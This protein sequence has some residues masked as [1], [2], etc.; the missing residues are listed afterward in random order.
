MKPLRV[1]IAG[2][3]TG[4]HI[5]PA[6]AIGHALK[7]MNAANELLFVGAKGKMEMS[8]VP[9]E[10]FNIVGL[11]IAGFNRSNILKNI[12]LPYK[13]LKSYFAARKILSE[14]KPDVVVGVGGYASFPMLNAAQ[15][16]GIPTLVQEQNSY[17]GKSNKLL[18]KKA[19]AICVAYENMDRFFPEE[20][21]ITTGNPVRKSISESVINEEQGK[22]WLGLDKTKTTIL[23]IGGS[24]GARSINEAIDMHLETILGWNVQLLWQTG[25]PYYQQAAARAEKFTGQVK[26]LEFI[27]EM[28]YAYAAS[29]TVVSRAGALS[30]AELC[31]VGKPVLF[32]PY[33]FAAEDHQTSNAMALVNKNAALMV[34]NDTV[35]DELLPKLKSLIDNVEM[36][37]VMKEN[38]E[39]LAIKDADKRIANKIVE[40]AQAN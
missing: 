27:R 6:V 22:A 3:G 21:L 7:A 1:I 38:L 26:V 35:M 14:F 17:A 30:I 4:G 15:G 2:G 23:I 20:K 18:G 8:K 24:L 13:M 33:P 9:L 19:K 32:V 10:G 12:S 5:F 11:D 40:I 16:K 25:T 29:D 36:R 39:A 34:R 28:D 31:I 37:E